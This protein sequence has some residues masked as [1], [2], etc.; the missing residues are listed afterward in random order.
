MRP[1]EA[2]SPGSGKPG[3][4]LAALAGA[5]REEAVSL[6]AMPRGRGAA[7]ARARV[8]QVGA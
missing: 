1:G 3:S 2:I 8:V 6:A 4:G 5:R 7:G